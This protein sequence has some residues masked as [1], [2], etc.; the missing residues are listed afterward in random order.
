L[1]PTRC[2]CGYDLRSHI[3]G[4]CCPECGRILVPKGQEQPAPIDYDFGP[5]LFVG[6]VFV[7]LTVVLV[8]A[9]VV[10]VLIA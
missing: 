4:D 5:L 9:L 7:V 10:V 6:A 3:P 8:I 1:G 2:N